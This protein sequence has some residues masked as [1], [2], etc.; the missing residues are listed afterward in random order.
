[1]RKLAFLLFP[2]M[3]FAQSEPPDSRE[4][5]ILRSQKVTFFNHECE[6]TESCDL[7][8]V[9]YVVE[10][11]KIR[12]VGTYHYGKRLSALYETD[13]V[14]ALENYTFIQFVRGCRYYSYLENGEVKKLFD[15]EVR[16]GEDWVIAC[17]PN[18]VVDTDNKYPD[19]CADE[20]GIS[21]HFMCRWKNDMRGDLFSRDGANLYGE[22]KPKFPILYIS[23]H[24]SNVYAIRDMD[25]A[26]NNSFI[27][28]TCLY[29]TAD[30]SRIV[31]LSDTQFAEPMHCFEWRNSLVYNY[32]TGE[33]EELDDAVPEC[34]GCKT[35]ENM[36]PDGIFFGK[37]YG[38]AFSKKPGVVER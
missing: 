18:W 8:R 3:L 19:Y 17:F 23:D 38:V 25:M 14:G 6:K 30:V 13:L 27:L 31:D 9:E 29:K 10:K 11:Y 7:K 28:R 21:R 35:Y 16:H 15:Y 12:I 2:F 22:G 26:V 32:V 37:L 33:F 34:G 24:P 5:I 4:P 1:M 20:E 36:L